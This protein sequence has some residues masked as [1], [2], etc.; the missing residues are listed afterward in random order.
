MAACKR[1]RKVDEDDS[2]SVAMRS[3][4]SAMIAME[5]TSS[6]G[7]GNTNNPTSNS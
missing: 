2:E 3:V 5:L 1:G 4:L 6:S 7:I